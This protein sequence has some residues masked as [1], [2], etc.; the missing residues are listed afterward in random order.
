MKIVRHNKQVD[1]E[2]IK[3]IFIYLNKYLVIFSLADSNWFTKGKSRIV[4]IWIS[5]RSLF[6]YR[7]AI[8]LSTT[9]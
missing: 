7:L 1:G 9:S 2:V 3:S 5:K 8:R 6:I 4:P